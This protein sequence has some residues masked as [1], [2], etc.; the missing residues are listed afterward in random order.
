MGHLA[1]RI[2]TGSFRKSCNALLPPS[3]INR[4]IRLCGPAKRRPPTLRPVALIQSLI[5]HVLQGAGTL[6]QHVKELTGLKLSES[7]LSQRR[8][9][10]AWQVFETLLEHALSPKAQ[11]DQHPHSFYKGWRLCGIDGTQFSVPNTPQILADLGKASTRRFKAAFAKVGAVVM[12]E[13]GLRHPIAAAIGPS[14]ESEMA[15]ARQLVDRLPAQSLSIWDRLYGVGALVALI[16]EAHPEGDREFL[17]R[18]RSNLKARVLE[19]LADGSALVEIRA[20][21]KKVVLREIRGRVRRPKGAWS[22]V[23]LWTSLLDPKRYPASELLQLYGRR[24]ES[25]VGYK[26]LK[27]DLRGSGLIQSQTPL[28]AAQEIAALLLAQAM[29]TEVRLEAAEKGDVPP[30]QI[31][32]IQ[33]L[34]WV[35]SLWQFLE[36]GADVLSSKQIAILIERTLSKIAASVVAPRRKRSSPRA[37]RQPVKSWPRLVKNSYSLGPTQYKITPIKN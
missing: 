11:P 26:E 2:D 35:R 18:V 3:L 32:F 16:W 13:L 30:L 22:E 37:V 20:G 23:R 15:L 6:G 31:S 17:L 24:W 27:V 4:V 34:R 10:L 19:L 21:K 9:N 12:V 5:F 36:V 33:T 28:T 25:E 8:T 14:G 29:L 7:A 1:S